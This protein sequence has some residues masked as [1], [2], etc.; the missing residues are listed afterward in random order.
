MRCSGFHVACFGCD[1][2]RQPR[3]PADV[4]EEVLL[5]GA[6]V[7]PRSP[8]SLR[9]FRGPTRRARDDLAGLGPKLRSGRKPPSAPHHPFFFRAGFLAS[10]FR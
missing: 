4:R 7:A 6:T 9:V 10:M 5:E 8:K 1:G 3:W 2:S